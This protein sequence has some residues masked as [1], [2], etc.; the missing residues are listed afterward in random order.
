MYFSLVYFCCHSN[1]FNLHL[2]HCSYCRLLISFLVSSF[3]LHLPQTVT[4]VVLLFCS[5]SSKQIIATQRRSNF[6]SIDMGFCDLATIYLCGLSYY[7]FPV[8]N[9][10]S[11]YKNFLVSDAFLLSL[12]FVSFFLF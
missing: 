5:S 1:S 7:C 10:C 4:L 6:F 12:L 8:I 3:F 11:N 9:S 2:L